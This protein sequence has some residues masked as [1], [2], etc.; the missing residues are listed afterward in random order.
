MIIAFFGIQVPLL[1]L[2]IYSVFSNPLGYQSIIRIL[3]FT[4]LASLLGTA[5]TLYFLYYLLFPVTLAS[6]KLREYITD[7][8]MPDLPSYYKDEAGQLMADVQYTVSHIDK[9]IRSLEKTS[10]TDYLTGI[11]NRFAAEKRLKEDIARSSRGNN[12]MSLILLDLDD[13]KRINDQYGHD[14]GDFCLKH[15]VNILKTNVRESDWMARWGGDEIMIMLFDSDEVFASKVLERII[16][17]LEENPIPT[18]QGLIKLTISVGVSQFKQSYDFESFFKKTDTA[19]L[20]AKR[21]GKGQIVYSSKIDIDD[22]QNVIELK[23]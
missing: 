8:K 2:I 3:V 12:K 13:F 5:F 18:T 9:L 4:V 23:N 21:R 11:D 14:I 6:S 15:A 22:D 19:L 17:G 16:S 20:E 1:T 10:T 7:K